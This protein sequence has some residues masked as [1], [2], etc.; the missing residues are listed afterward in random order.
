MHAIYLDLYPLSCDLKAYAASDSDGFTKGCKVPNS[1]GVV[2]TITMSFPFYLQDSH[3][4]PYLQAQ[5]A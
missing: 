1:V 3:M 4:T 2:S 5:T